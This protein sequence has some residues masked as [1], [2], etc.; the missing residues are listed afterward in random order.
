MTPCKTGRCRRNNPD[1]DDRRLP[2]PHNGTPVTRDD[3]LTEL[4]DVQAR[5]DAA[6][7]RFTRCKRALPPSLAEPAAYRR[8]TEL[9]ALLKETPAMQPTC[10]HPDCNTLCTD[11]DYCR[12][13]CA[14]VCPAHSTHR[15]VAVDPMNPA[16]PAEHWETP[17]YDDPRR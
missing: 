6:Y 15:H 5:I 17:W 12:D 7:W 16:D 13:C 4:R 9:N 3:L 14:H 10:A 2:A 11:R 8:R 1:D